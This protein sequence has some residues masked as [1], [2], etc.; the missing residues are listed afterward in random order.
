MIRR[1]SASF[2]TLEELAWN[3]WNKGLLC[4]ISQNTVIR[5]HQK[6]LDVCTEIFTDTLTDG[7]TRPLHNDSLNN[8]KNHWLSSLRTSMPE[9]AVPVTELSKP[10]NRG[11]IHCRSKIFNISVERKFDSKA[12]PASISMDTEAG[13]QAEYSSV[14]RDEPKIE[15]SCTWT[16]PYSFV[17][18]KWTTLLYHAWYMTVSSVK[19]FPEFVHVC[20]S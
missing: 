15:W 11:S 20:V 5:H 4:N 17:A 7:R 2:I 19:N 18:Y 13:R 10:F 12:H 9:I 16:F 1:N 14:S 6:I 8:F 3:T